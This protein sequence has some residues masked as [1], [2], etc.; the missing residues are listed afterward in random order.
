LHAVAAESGQLVWKV[1]TAKKFRVVPNF[2]GVGSHPVVDGERLIVM[3]GGSPPESQNLGPDDLARVVGNGTGIVA[4]DKRTGAVR[5]A[6][7][8]ELASYATPQLATI[9]GRRWCFAFCRGGLVGFDPRSGQVDFHYPWRAPD[10]ASVNISTPVVSSNEVFI[11]EA[12]G[13][14]SS[15][16]RVRPGACE[17]VWCDSPDRKRSMLC[18][19]NTPILHDGY[20]YGSSGQSESSAHLRCVEWKTGRVM[21]SQPRLK[22]TA[23]LYVDGH[24]VGLSEDGVLRLIKATPERYAPLAEVVLH[25]APDGPPLIKAPAF[26]APILAHG[27]LYVRG[28]DRV[29]CLRLLKTAAE[30]PA[31]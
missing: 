8:N 11:S 5:Y 16:V 10:L 2:F 21:W 13:P 4:F 14:G 27:L 30:P 18:Y 17:V 31:R 26:A 7:T 3:I 12:Y 6:L 1:D 19:W 24:F 15:L 9:D 20:L 23:L 25:A 29:V 28:W 22:R